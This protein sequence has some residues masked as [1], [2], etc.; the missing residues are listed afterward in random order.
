MN[1]IEGFQMPLYGGFHKIISLDY[2]NRTG[3]SVMIMDAF[4]TNLIFIC[5]GYS[6]HRRI[7]FAIALDV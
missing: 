7:S 3:I 4:K 2:K 1:Q 5:S 6:S